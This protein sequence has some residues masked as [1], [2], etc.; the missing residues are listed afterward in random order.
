MPGLQD[1]AHLVLRLYVRHGVHL[2]GRPSY[3]EAR[4]SHHV[5]RSRLHVVHAR[6]PHGGARS[7]P[8]VRHVCALLHVREVCLLA[9]LRDLVVHAL[10]GLGV[11]LVARHAGRLLP[12][13]LPDINT[14]LDRSWKVY[15]F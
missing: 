8:H 9:G 4:S 10:R 5:R 7:G 1:L 13:H 14:G 11:L 12:H 3:D 2:A 15:K 6:V